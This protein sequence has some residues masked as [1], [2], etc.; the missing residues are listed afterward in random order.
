MRSSEFSE[1]CALQ[2]KPEQ[3]EERG[4]GNLACTVIFFIVTYKADVQRREAACGPRMDRAYGPCG[5]RSPSLILCVRRVQTGSAT[6]T[7]AGFPR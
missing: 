7:M 3:G 2:R 5:V 6:R 4:R 1:R